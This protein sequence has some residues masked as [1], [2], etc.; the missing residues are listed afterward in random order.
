MPTEN[1]ISVM[2]NNFIIA[3]KQLEDVRDIVQ[4]NPLQYKRARESG[5]HSAEDEDVSMCGNGIKPAY[6]IYEVKKRRGL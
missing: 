5:G 3:L 6:M 4:Q 1:E 2:L